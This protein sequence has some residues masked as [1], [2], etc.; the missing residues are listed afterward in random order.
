MWRHPLVGE[1]GR[2]RESNAS[3][4]MLPE[5]E[6]RF[7]G[8]TNRW[9]VACRWSILSERCCSSTQ[10][11]SGEGWDR[12]RSE[13]ELAHEH[14]GELGVVERGCC[15]VVG[16]ESPRIDGAKP[17]LSA[18]DEVHD[19][20]VTVE[21]RVAS[22][23]HPV[24]G[25][26]PQPRSTAFGAIGASLRCDCSIFE[27][28][29]RR[30][31]RSLVR[32]DHP[33]RDRRCSTQRQNAHR[34][35]WGEDQFNGFHASARAG[36]VPRSPEVSAQQ[37]VGRVIVERCRDA[38]GDPHLPNGTQGPV[39]VEVIELCSSP[40]VVARVDVAT[41]GDPEHTMSMPTGCCC[42]VRSVVLQDGRSQIGAESPHG[43]RLQH[44]G[45][46]PSLN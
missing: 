38:E 35:L 11:R 46:D 45:L 17:P 13:P 10:H 40:A 12:G 24:G 32:C 6:E 34:L 42:S 19:E 3:E 37:R 30:S 43:W 1:D 5:V 21:V 16:E 22:T 31:D 2:S 4:P 8:G 18:L 27:V 39:E 20:D 7:T 14:T 44:R 28:G 36:E 41:R 23:T 33:A 9:D 26:E 25:G 15:S 29:E